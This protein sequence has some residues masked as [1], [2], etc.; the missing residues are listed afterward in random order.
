MIKL[1]AVFIL[2]FMAVGNIDWGTDI[3]SFDFVTTG[4]E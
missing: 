4:T 1:I 2:L 3:D